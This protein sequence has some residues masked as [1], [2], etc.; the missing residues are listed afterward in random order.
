MT[1]LSADRSPTHKDRQG[2]QHQPD[3]LTD[4][5]EHQ[6][7]STSQ[8]LWD[9]Q[10]RTMGTG[11]HAPVAFSNPCPNP[12]G[13]SMGRWPSGTVPPPQQPLMG[14]GL[15]RPAPHT[16]STDHRVPAKS[17]ITAVSA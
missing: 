14:T 16:T 12:H 13:S 6:A 5:A 3:E 8:G 17:R 15:C 10:T 7:I 4:Q 11:A 2:K 9:G 1:A